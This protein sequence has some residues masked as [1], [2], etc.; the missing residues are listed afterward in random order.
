[1]INKLECRHRM[2]TIEVEEVLYENTGMF[3]KMVCISETG[4]G[5]R[6]GWKIGRLEGWTIAFP[7][8][9][10][11]PSFQPKVSTYFIGNLKHAKIPPISV[12]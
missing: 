6:Q 5:G 8:S 12:L 9:S 10:I 2:S 7:H 1:M 4:K 11:L 3:Q